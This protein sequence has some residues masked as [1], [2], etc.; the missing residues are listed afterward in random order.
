[1]VE[2]RTPDIRVITTP[3]YGGRIVSLLSL[4]SGRE[5]LWSKTPGRDVFL[6]NTAEPFSLSPMVG[7]DECFPTIA[8]CTVAGG[9]YADHGDL[10]SRSWTILEADETRIKLRV[11]LPGPGLSFERTLRVEAAELALSYRV[12]HHGTQKVPWLWAF[13]PLFNLEAGDRLELSS[14]LPP[15]RTGSVRGVPALHAGRPFD[16]PEPVQGV[17]LAQGILAPNT[18]QYAKLFFRASGFPVASIVNSQT[19][20]SMDI[21]WDA[22]EIPYMGFWLT[23]GGWNGYHHWA[24][25]PTHYPAEHPLAV[26]G[27]DSPPPELLPGDQVG[28]N[29]SIK[30]KSPN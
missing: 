6:P 23:R 3:E 29:I 1:M 13:H 8:A 24:L 26:P 17:N 14:S 5:W 16:W 19:G 15:L 12:C 10:H 21:S 2:L 25:E 11:E 30:L 20:E 9:K 22:R 27:F 18:G 7:I 28:W 4:K